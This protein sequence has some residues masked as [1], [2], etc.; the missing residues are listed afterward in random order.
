[1][2]G[3]QI[4]TAHLI[5]IM[6]ETLDLSARVSCLWRE[7]RHDWLLGSTLKLRQGCVSRSERGLVIDEVGTSTPKNVQDVA[8]A[9]LYYLARRNS[10]QYFASRLAFRTGEEIITHV[11]RLGREHLALRA[12]QEARSRHE[13]VV[14]TPNHHPRWSR[15]RDPVWRRMYRAADHVFALTRV[16]AEALVDLGVPHERITVT[17]I[18][19]VLA[20]SIPSRQSFRLENDLPE[21][22]YI[23]FL[24]QQFKYKRV[25]L[26]IGAFERLAEK[27]LDL[28]LIIAGPTSR[29]T[30]RL[31]GRSKYSDRIIVLGSVSLSSK[32]ALLT[33]AELLLFPSEQESFGGVL[34]EAAAVGTPFVASDIPQLSEVVKS[35]GWGVCVPRT[36]VAFAEAAESILQSRPQLSNSE[37]IKFRSSL[38]AKYGWHTLAQTYLRT[39]GA[40]VHS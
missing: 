10:A 19:P 22:R 32:S 33:E 5:K 21:G 20:E 28:I 27:Y 29:S 15:R 34:V 24:G 30:L 25:D 14:L 26:A 6:R 31:W 4:H 35:L 17:G 39:Y 7:T 18:G 37:S 23:A 36:A 16:E 2:G 1:M 11:V 3:A 13:P 38:E 40:L 12:F 8:R 9:A